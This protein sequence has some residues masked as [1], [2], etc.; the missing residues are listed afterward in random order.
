MWA[1]GCVQR[2]I[3]GELYVRERERERE[4]DED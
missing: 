1:R 4:R 3:R 2:E